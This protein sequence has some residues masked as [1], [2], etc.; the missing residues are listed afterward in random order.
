MRILL[1]QQAKHDT[2][3]QS[4]YTMLL[5]I[6]DEGR[7]CRTDADS[8]VYVGERSRTKHFHRKIG[9]YPISREA[10]EFCCEWGVER[11]ELTETTQGTTYVFELETYLNAKEEA[12]FDRSY[13]VAP[14]EDAEQRP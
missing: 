8:R 1:G 12:V 13:H 4:G 7:I 14:V 9:G 11:I 6:G 10:L 3:K 2:M 5:D